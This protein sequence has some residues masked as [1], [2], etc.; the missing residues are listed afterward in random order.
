[1]IDLK[2]IPVSFWYGWAIILITI[3]WGNLLNLKNKY[4][5]YFMIMWIW[6]IVLSTWTRVNIAWFYKWL[7]FDNPAA[8][9]AWFIFRDSN[10]LVWLV[11]FCFAVLWATWIASI[12]SAIKNYKERVDKEKKY[13]LLYKNVIYWDK[14]VLIINWYNYLFVIFL[15]VTF[16]SYY[17]YLK[18]FHKTFINH[19]YW[20]VDIPKDYYNFMD[21]QKQDTNSWKYLYLPRYESVISPW[22]DFW[23]ADW[24]L[25][26]D[27]Q[28]PTSSFDIYSTIKKTYNPLEWATTYLWNFYEYITDYLSN[29]RWK[30]IAKY[31]YL[32]WVDKLVF[33]NDM[34]WMHDEYTKI[35]NNLAKQDNLK[36]VKE[37]W[38]FTIFKNKDNISYW[39][40][41]LNNI[42]HFWWMKN[43]ETLF[44][45]P[46]FDYKKYSSIFVEQDF[47]VNTTKWLEKPWD[48]VSVIDKNDYIMNLFSED[49]MVY[50]FDFNNYSDWFS[51]FAKM[52]E[53]VP[54]W[55]WHLKNIWINNIW[56]FWLNK[57]FV[58]TY[59]WAMVDV[60]PYEYIH[61][62]WKDII[63]FKSI[64]NI[65]D[66]FLANDESSIKLWLEKTSKYDEIPAIKWEVMTWEWKLWK[67]WI[68][69]NLKVKENMWYVFEVVVSWK[70]V[71]SI[72][73]K[74]KFLDKD[75]K[76]I[77]VSY[78]SAPRF[79]S[80]FD[81][82]KF[83]GQFVTPVWTKEM[84]FSF[85]TLQ[86]PSKKVYWFIH[87]IK[88]KELEKETK[89]N[90]VNMDYDFKKTWEYYV[91]SRSFDNIKWWE[92]NIKILNKNFVINTK[93]KNINSFNWRRLWTIKI[94]ELWKQDI[95]LTNKIWF[96][97]INAIA[98]IPKRKYDAKIKQ[99][100]EWKN[101]TSQMM[102]FEAEDDFELN[103]WIQSND[104]NIDLSSWRA[105]N[106]DNWILKRKISILKDWIYN[107]YLNLNK[108]SKENEYTISLI[109]KVNN[110]VIYSKKIS[111]TDNNLFILKW[112]NIPYWDY[113]L[114]I[115]VSDLS[116]NLVSTNDLRLY[117]KK[118]DLFDKEELLKLSDEKWCSF[119]Q[120]LEKTNYNFKK[121]NNKFIFNLK[122]WFSCFFV[123]ITHW[124]LEVKPWERYYISYLL[125]KYNTRDLHAKI[126]LFD[127]D[128]K[129]LDYIYLEDYED[130]LQ[131]KD[132]DNKHTQYILKIP[133]NVSYIQLNFLSKQIQ[134]FKD[135]NIVIS[136]LL[137]KNYSNLAWVDSV[138]L[139]D[140]NI[141]FDQNNIVVKTK[142]IDDKKMSNTFKFKISDYFG[143]I[144]KLKWIQE[145]DKWWVLQILESYTPLWQAN[146]WSWYVRPIISNIFLNG[147]S[148]NTNISN[149]ND[150]NIDYVPKKFL[151]FWYWIS[152][153]TLI[154][155]S[156][157]LVYLRFI[158]PKFNLSLKII[159][160]LKLLWKKIKSQK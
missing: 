40:V 82:L 129:Y 62:K 81:V 79:A 103:W 159:N 95:K 1:M 76:E 139:Y 153:L 87:D 12:L 22:Y 28:R 148:I 2:T 142:V 78:V 58:Y 19:F 85:N 3:F 75:W 21:Y 54:D 60:E 149:E 113:L 141:N 29:W 151:I 13:L 56:D 84:A 120:W 34:H 97:A 30:N 45:I 24:N 155:I 20:V 135:S 94:N 122:R 91:L 8:W 50:P 46:F 16:F 92:Y 9:Q 89:E 66:L 102:I 39:N 109:S 72:H 57:W 6:F 156:T 111:V 140:N 88:L 68:M 70:W 41:F 112:L 143:K 107:I 154:F 4:T 59:A 146:F 36:K 126:K 61:D 125:Q 80:D 93:T 123:T 71:N 14:K 17:Y 15:I 160:Y 83:S 133:E 128:K 138:L 32:I 137:I 136:D 43:L 69:K 115:N 48:I 5:L 31:L 51:R 42:Y 38:F 27:P 99:L 144:L 18:P 130:K 11:A 117:D 118:L 96:N 145:Y 101:I 25:V 67:A 77:W 150:A 53:D 63:D 152:F 100:Q 119:N 35:L 37:I 74:V 131:Y 124:M 158:K 121:L 73:W 64:V 52:R 44:N 127:K 10:K 98:F 147:Y 104:S 110:S 106:F 134:D 86:N 105:V 108:F 90:V 55:K 157:Y 23:V 47:K 132:W 65:S 49:D 33:H 116:K 114:Q 7:V 26:E